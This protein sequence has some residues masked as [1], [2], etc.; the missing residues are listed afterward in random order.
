MKVYAVFKEG[1]YRHE[2][3]GI[4]TSLDAAKAAALKLITS[5]PDDHHEYEVIPFELDVAATQNVYGARRSYLSEDDPVARFA[6]G[7][8]EVIVI[9]DQS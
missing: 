6:R 1:S 9:L 2:C 8:T 3:G 5:E 4:F 7:G